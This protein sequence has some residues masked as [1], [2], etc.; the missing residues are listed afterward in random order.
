MSC[1]VI[2]NANKTIN[3]VLADNGQES[4]LF[5]Q[6]NENLF[7]GGASEASLNVFMAVRS[8]DSENVVKNN[9]NEPLMFFQ[10]DNGEV[11]EDMESALISTESGKFGFGVY[12][13]TVGFISAGSFNTDNSPVSS[14]LA[15]SVRNGVLSTTRNYNKETGESFL[16]GK[17]EFPST[18][19]ASQSVFADNIEED[20]GLAV[21][22]SKDGINVIENTN[23]FIQVVKKDGTVE[24]L[25][26]K[27]AREKL[28]ERNVEN[29]A[30]IFFKTED[31]LNKTFKKQSPSTTMSPIFKNNLLS[32]LNGM[33]FSVLS[34]DEYQKSYEVR[35]GGAI[36]VEGL[37]DLSNKVVAIAEG[38]DVESVMTEEVAHL[39]IETYS[40]QASIADALVEVVSTQEYRDNAEIY[41]NRYSD[42]LEGVQLEEKVRKE[43]LGKVLAK[44]M[45]ESKINQP[46]SFISNIWQRFVKFI[47]SRFT[48]R[49]RTVIDSLTKRIVQDFSDNNITAFSNK[50][51]DL[52]T[53][54]SLSVNKGIQESL[55]RVSQKFKGISEASK[56]TGSQT[57][58][59]ANEIKVLEGMT[60]VD[61][62]NQIDKIVSVL[63]TNLKTFDAKSKSGDMSAMDFSIFSDL[64]RIIFPELEGFLNYTT[65]E[66]TFTDAPT[67][68][69]ADAVAQDIRKTMEGFSLLNSRVKADSL[70]DYAEIMAT[71]I[72][73]N[74]NLTEDQKKEVVATFNNV[75]KDISTPQL[76]FSPLSESSSPFIRMLGRVI[77]D[78]YTSV[79]NVFRNFA[80]NAS[81]MFKDNNWRASQ[82]RI[83][84]KDSYYLEDYY[85][86]QAMDN[87]ILDEVAQAIS[88]ITNTPVKE[89]RPL[90]NHN[91]P[92][93]V[94]ED[95]LKKSD[96]NISEEDLMNKKDQVDKEY[97]KARYNNKTHRFSQAKLDNDDKLKDIA[98]V[99]EDSFVE[100]DAYRQQ[101]NDITGKYYVNGRLNLDAMTPADKEARDSILMARKL[102]LSAIASSGEIMDGLEVRTWEEMT[103][104]QKQAV[105]E[106]SIKLTGNNFDPTT[107]R[108][109]K[110]VVLQDGFD[111]NNLSL[112]ARYSLDMNNFSLASMM[113][114]ESNPQE[115]GKI[116]SE[117]ISNVFETLAD[118]YK[119][120]PQDAEV[121]GIYMD[122]A[123]D[124]YATTEYTQEFY[125]YL[126]TNN[127]DFV[128]NAQQ[129]IAA[130]EDDIR[131]GMLTEA[132]EAYKK[133]SAQKSELIKAYR[134]NDN[135]T[136]VSV[137]SLTEPIRQ[138]W[139]EIDEQIAEIRKKFQ[140]EDFE[141]ESLTTRVLSSQFEKMR[142]E[143]G[144]TDYDFALS[145]MTQKR[146]LDVENFKNYLSLSATNSVR[147]NKRFEAI[148]DE[149]LSE[150]PGTD[151]NA[152]EDADLV[153]ELATLYAKKSLPSYFYGSTFKNI[154]QTKLDILNGLRDGVITV[155]DI[156]TDNITK[157]SKYIK[158][159][160]KPE[161][162]EYNTP[163]R[164]LDPE[165]NPIKG[166]VP[167]AKFHSPEYLAK[168][169]ISE[170][171][172][173]NASDITEL[174]ATSNVNDF[175]LLKFLVQNNKDV[176]EKYNTNTNIMLRPQITKS[177]YEKIKGSYK[178]KENVGNIKET[179]KE[180]FSDRIDEMEYG[181]PD[182]SNV[183][184]K[185]IPK[186]HRR[187]VEDPQH[188]T[189]NLFEASMTMM[190]DA[191]LYLK[192]LE[193]KKRVDALINQ[194]ENREYKKG[195]LL[196]ANIKIKGEVS[197]TVKGMKE[198]ADNYL[199]GIKQDTKMEINVFGKSIDMTRMLSKM[200]R[201]SSKINLGYSAMIPLTSLTTGVYNNFENNLVKDYFSKSSI[202]RARASAPADMAKYIS[203]EGQIYN[204]TK[205]GALIEMFGLK[206]VGERFN[207]SA[208][209]R[210]ER[211]L[212]ESM[213]MFDNIMNVPVLYQS[214]Y[215]TLYDYR[216]FE[217]A[218]GSKKGFLNYAGFE[219]YM[220]TTTPGIKQ[221]DIK[222]AWKNIEKQSF[223]DAIDFDTNTGHISVK[224]EYVD[225][226]S[227]EKIDSTI[228]D[229]SAKVRILGQQVD[230][231]MSETDKVLASRNVLLNTLLQHRGFLFINLARAFKGRR[232]NFAT[233]KSEEGHYTSVISLLTNLTQD[234]GNL[235][236]SLGRMEED[237]KRNLKRVAFRLAMTMLIL[238]LAKYLK[239][240]DDEDDTFAEDLTRVITYRTY[241]EVADLSPLGMIKTVMSSIKQPVV[242]MGT[243][244][245][246][247]KA[248]DELTDSEVPWSEKDYKNLKKLTM[249]GKTYDQV[250]D[251]H[252][253][254]NSWLYHKQTDIPEL[255]N[256]DPD[257]N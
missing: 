202:N 33:G 43:I 150:N 212:A 4:E 104:A 226:L 76:L 157:V 149:I 166:S 30:D 15:K 165:Y 98:D 81:K 32:F 227:Q 82:S 113:Q 139:N 99:S 42:E 146:R 44:Q 204:K 129:Q 67:K 126:N 26:K 8:L 132:L 37:L 10:N 201:L 86:Y 244:E 124:N 112:D 89:V 90:L 176:N 199:Y 127:A 245:T 224:Q 217:S 177:G 211:I 108:K 198:I 25:N 53:Y 219:N 63:K 5:T 88:N 196:N 197:Q 109:S 54:F 45:L 160:I 50:S 114:R 59:S 257:S 182:F 19:R 87:A 21:K 101:L 51:G 184:I 179:I 52:G 189:E 151:F 84:K 193:T 203:A 147:A 253:Y 20:L 163:E 235:A 237:Q 178:L 130:E 110:Y 6:V 57:I 106:M 91:S 188:L 250:S 14:F 23:P 125:D 70:N 255:F 155:E 247:Y 144:K 92:R 78:M 103:P 48:P 118:N 105:N 248:Y 9:T 134:S 153:A 73:N 71:Y 1:N 18:V 173:N 28:K 24:V 240:S 243:L 135:S 241:N 191:E 60:Q 186:M 119:N 174:N 68:K 148:L 249:F 236:K 72:E 156:F 152:L 116:I 215:A 192:K 47:Q 221:A 79:D 136:E 220:K 121:Y 223:M 12:D 61:S 34:L 100:Y 11:F 162:V 222:N 229:I 3:T 138:L 158:Y 93:N 2:R 207:N 83:V 22:F 64:Y 17:G 252:S 254:T 102:R 185:V 242:M 115:Y 16:K 41:R 120:N 142:K 13:D 27:E 56:K 246:A 85:D 214:L 231:V 96:P 143:S 195:G 175:S 218:D 35:H 95:L 49:K 183:G 62:L 170:E 232:Y 128:A 133:L 205:L 40:D 213:F 171:D 58:I 216:Y 75:N 169:G 159:S 154:E 161:Y 97:R 55:K 94:A 233:G 74:D 145:Q 225:K 38:V 69:I 117:P 164:F 230:G 36:G 31:L 167:R 137:N 29:K 238:Q 251:L 209:T 141:T 65:Q 234:R 131:Y 172:Y 140:T 206:S 180:S 46:S 7:L 168:Y 200:Q 107:I 194:A 181:D 208:S 80:H 111:K 228:K 190:R 122:Q 66:N 187:K 39:I 256:Y 239:G 77:T 123:L 210:G